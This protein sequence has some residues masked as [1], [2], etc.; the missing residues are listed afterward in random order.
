QRSSSRHGNSTSLNGPVLRSARRWARS[1]HL[2]EFFLTHLI[3][4][5]SMGK[6][7]SWD[8][9]LHIM[10]LFFWPRDTLFIPF[11]FG[12]FQCYTWA[13]LYA[14]HIMEMVMHQR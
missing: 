12:F 1:A 13:S 8:H 3:S 6:S 5:L 9:R 4:S 7:S 2:H 10:S 11:L 14:I